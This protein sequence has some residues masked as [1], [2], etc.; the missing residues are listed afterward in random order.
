MNLTKIIMLKL[1]FKNFKNFFQA[2]VTDLFHQF[3]TILKIFQKVY[4]CKISANIFYFQ[5]KKKKE[6][7]YYFF[8]Q[9]KLSFK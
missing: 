7:F 5:K 9:N 1:Q 3:F 8:I 2:A 4:I 6:L